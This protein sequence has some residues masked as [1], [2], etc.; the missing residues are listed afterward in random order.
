[1]WLVNVCPTGHDA[2]DANLFTKF[3]PS[4]CAWFFFL[5]LAQP[6]GVNCT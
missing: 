2:T 6:S 5:I 1:M 3:K 4:P